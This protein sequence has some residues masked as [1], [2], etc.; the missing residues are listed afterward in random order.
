MR[1]LLT[2]AGLRMGLFVLYGAA[3]SIASPLHV[4]TAPFTED[5]KNTIDVFESASRGVA[6]I[7]SRSTT[8]SQFSK[9]ERESSTGTGFVID[10]QGHILTAFH[11]I[12]GMNQ[13]DVIL[14]HGH[15]LSARLVGTAP[16]MDIALLQV[17][18][19]L[20]ELHPLSLGDSRSLR[21]GQK[22]IALGNPFGLHNSITVGV[23]SALNRSLDQGPVEL[24]EAY[25]QTDTAI[26]PG[27]SGGPLLNSAG[28]V[29]GINRAIIAGA[30]NVG[31]AVPI[32]LA[33]RILPDLIEMGHP[34]RPQLGF[35]GSAITPSIAKLFGFPIDHGYLVEEVL[36]YSP[37]A[38]AGLKAGERVV[39]LGDKAYVLGGDVITAVNGR[40]VTTA[41]EIS[42]I[43]LESRPGQSLRLSVYREKQTLEISIPLKKM[44]M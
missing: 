30:Q 27:N 31:F 39:V 32:H 24:E 9:Q 5:E 29:V 15:R 21:V 28:E 3:I 33:R 26:N 36:P 6:H 42:K 23:V 22:V 19:P 43:L 20:E 2:R 44:Q 17:E 34:Y 8:D 40:T 41:A 11:V 37:A 14:S 10:K 7:E 35:G 18:A 38:S 4:Q 12:Q 13:V 16:Q 25:I 1:T